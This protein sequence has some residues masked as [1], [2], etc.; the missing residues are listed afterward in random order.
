LIPF[1]IDKSALDQT[2]EFEL[3]ERKYIPC[4]D[5]SEESISA[6][7]K[8]LVDQ[9][10]AMTVRDFSTSNT[11]RSESDSNLRFE[12][13]QKIIARHG[14]VVRE[15]I[16]THRRQNPISIADLR[17]KVNAS[18]YCDFRSEDELLDVLARLKQAAVLQGVFFDSEIAF[19]ANER[20]N[21]KRDLNSEVKTAIAKKALA[22]VEDDMTI[23]VDGGSTTQEFVNELCRRLAAKLIYGLEIVTN[24][25]PAA[26]SIIECLNELEASDR[27]SICK[28]SLLGGVCR[29]ISM[30]TLQIDAAVQMSSFL[31][32][33]DATHL[34]LS[35]VG[36]NGVNGE[37]GIANNGKALIETKRQFFE[38][39]AACCALME[40][41]KL[42]IQ[43]RRVFAE[44]GERL[45]IYTN[46]R[47]DD[48]RHYEM[49]SGRG[50]RIV[51]C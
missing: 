31:D 38:R 18:P 14:R 50:S 37:Q 10:F 43:Q 46:H 41:R 23:G 17:L 11:E 9:L 30:S 24:S 34:D 45:S 15:A 29:P 36:A 6:A 42:G 48:T 49:I 47:D 1:V 27:D 19:L 3:N 51:F 44:F 21:Q 32:S 33:V 7:S 13:A 16:F 20:V 8:Q 25:I 35:F 39:S 12:E 22:L 26:L 40:S 5:F 4:Y 2:K 28:V